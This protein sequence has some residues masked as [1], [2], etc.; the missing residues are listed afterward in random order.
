[1]AFRLLPTFRLARQLSK[2]ISNPFWTV[3][4]PSFWWDYNPRLPSESEIFQDHIGMIEKLMQQPVEIPRPENIRRR[5]PG[6]S[7]ATYYRYSE[8]PKREEKASPS[9]QEATQHEAETKTETMT[10]KAAEEFH[11]S[12]NLSEFSPEEIQVK[13]IGDN[14][15]YVEAK[16]VSKKD[17]RE[18]E[19]Y[20]S[21][22]Y[23]I[24]DN[25]DIEAIKSTISKD[26][27][28]KM[29]APVMNKQPP[30]P[31]EKILPIDHDASAR[32]EEA[33]VDSAEN[34]DGGNPKSNE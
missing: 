6:M 28:L 27:T 4:R 25:V 19:R 14:V 29:T 20:F 15:L 13:L 5:H 3:P 1:M 22:Y 21:H 7:S 32:V 33:P 2:E 12:F 9:E 23:S 18:V 16:H 10:E 17:G 31:T 26:G 8:A 30:Q 24:P 34:V 11:V